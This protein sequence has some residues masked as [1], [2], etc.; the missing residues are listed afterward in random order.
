MP[1]TA[2]QTLHAARNYLHGRFQ[3]VEAAWIAIGSPEQLDNPLFVQMSYFFLAWD[4]LHT[5]HDRAQQI[6]AAQP[7][8]RRARRR[9]LAAWIRSQLRRDPACLN[10][11]HL[12]PHAIN[13]WETARS[14]LRR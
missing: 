4:I 13:L 1:P 11:L 10:I 12:D 14:A 8:Q 3:A 7:P 9:A 6:A 2:V 5:A